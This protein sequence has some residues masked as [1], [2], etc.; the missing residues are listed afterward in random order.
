MQIIIIE[1]DDPSAETANKIN[2]IH[3]TKNSN[4]GRYGFIEEFQE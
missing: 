1:N 4:K 2:Y 3:F